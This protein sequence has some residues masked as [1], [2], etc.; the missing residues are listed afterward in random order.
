MENKKYINQVFWLQIAAY[1]TPSIFMTTYAMI[2]VWIDFETASTILQSPWNGLNTV[3]FV[4]LIP[5]LFRKQLEKLVK[6]AEEG[7]HKHIR[8]KLFYGQWMFIGVSI[9]YG[10]TTYPFLV[11]TGFPEEK[12]MISS[13]IVLLCNTMVPVPFLTRV[14]QRLDILFK[15]VAISRDDYFTGIAQRIRITNLLPTIVSISFLILGIYMLLIGNMNEDGSFNISIR[16]MVIRLSII[17]VISMLFILIPM[18]VLGRRITSQIRVVE[19]YAHKIAEGDLRDSLERTSS[20]ELGMVTNAVNDMRNDLQVMML[21]I[22]KVSHDIEEVGNI[23]Q[24]LSNDLEEESTSQVSYTNDMS[25][26]IEQMTVNI[27]GNSRNAEQ[28]DALSSE[29]GSL[30]EDSFEI[31]TRN[32][33]A[34]NEIV[35][36]VKV[37][38]EI[39]NQTNLLAINATIEAAST[40]DF[41]RGFAVVAK[42][43]RVL[44]EKSKESAKEINE[45]SA[46]CMDLI[47]QTQESISALKPKAQTTS[48]LSEQI[49]KVS[50]LTR[51]EGLQVNE[52]I[53]HLNALA[54]NNCE[55][56]RD[57]SEQAFELGHQVYTLNEL[58]DNIKA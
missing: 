37:I 38:N 30:A 4:I 20:D 31:V 13:V 56:S 10:L 51:D 16:E 39:A 55:V 5:I 15:D 17:G 42:E 9:I 28:C 53:H 22:Q 47:I 2:L 8:K 24:D 6:D 26:S 50:T 14:I 58:I 52:K 18:F 41:G 57:L 19:R 40:G 7:N 3:I 33:D 11:L 36:K 29:V 49:A 43:V 1:L 34:I 35:E 27:E 46:T 54:Q 32:V 25:N 48:D 21:G 45:L 12:I 23:I 44:A